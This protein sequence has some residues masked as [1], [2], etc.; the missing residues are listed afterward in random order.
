MI[1]VIH[2]SK[3][4]PQRAFDTY[5][6]IVIGANYEFEYILSIDADERDGAEYKK[7]FGNE[8]VTI[9]ESD[10]TNVV[11]AV[12]IG[13][14]RSK[15]DILLLLSDDF[16]EM[17]KGWDSM[18]IEA[19]KDKEFWFLKTFDG[20]N[21]WLITLPIMDRKAYE[22]LGYLYNP[23][24]KHMFADTDQTCLGD[25]MDITITRNDILFKH[26]HYLVANNKDSVNE[27]ADATWEQGEKAYLQRHIDNYGLK[28]SEIKGVINNSS[29]L[30]WLK[31][32]LS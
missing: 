6:K 12:N 3:N 31:N 9:I 11:E 4:R 22:Y 19:T 26:N 20:A 29:H 14:K 16:D 17:P 13:A 5:D 8:K 30:E 21:D 32:K 24:Y 23:L 1:T 27:K 28:E 2:P 25:L 18:I 7:L 10:S 15:G